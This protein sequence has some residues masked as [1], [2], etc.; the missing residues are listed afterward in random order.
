MTLVA[1]AGS[2]C[3]CSLFALGLRSGRFAPPPLAP[4][5]HV[6]ARRF[7]PLRHTRQQGS[8][9][10][11]RW[12]LTPR[13]CS[14]QQRLPPPLPQCSRGIADT[15]IVVCLSITWRMT[16]T[17]TR[18]PSSWL[19]GECG[20]SCCTCAGRHQQSASWQRQYGYG[21]RREQ[22]SKEREQS[23]EH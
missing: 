16:H 1:N 9:S 12:A 14:S 5:S 19:E 17:Q 8:A 11:T 4:L 10:R 7:M 23:V 6:G 15:V 3:A 2:L 13:R 20:M 21:E 22:H 18:A